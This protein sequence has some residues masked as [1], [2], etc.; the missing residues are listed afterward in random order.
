MSLFIN[1]KCIIILNWKPK[2][3]NQ[4]LKNSAKIQNKC[5]IKA[6]CCY[7]SSTDKM[8]NLMFMELQKQ[9]WK[10]IGKCLIKNWQNKLK[11]SIVI[12]PTLGRKI[13]GASSKLNT[14]FQ[15]SLTY[16]VRPCPKKGKWLKCSLSQISTH[17]S[18][19]I[20]TCKNIVF[21]GLVK[22]KVFARIASFF[23]VSSLSHQ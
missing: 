4:I 10:K 6:I 14:K 23:L 3:Q 13:R 22:T 8:W 16:S 12:Q 18:L 9:I 21:P 20:H 1:S 15:E 5:Q 2:Q 11:V 7:L 19:F 17:P